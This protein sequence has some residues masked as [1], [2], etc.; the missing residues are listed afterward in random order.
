M[1]SK[2]IIFASHFQCK[3][4]DENPKCLMKNPSF[5]RQNDQ[6]GAKSFREPCYWN[7]NVRWQQL[8]KMSFFCKLKYLTN[9]SILLWIR[10]EKIQNII[11][12]LFLIP[13]VKTSQQTFNRVLLWIVWPVWR[14]WHTFAFKRTRGSSVD[15]WHVCILLWLFCISVRESVNFNIESIHF[16]K[17]SI[18]VVVTHW[19]HVVTLSFNAKVDLANFWV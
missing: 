1:S 14:V 19:K 7:M 6:W 18:I 8:S 10:L 4:T 16:L 17:P 12:A 13:H 15:V 5:V 9:N 2:E 3:M 11:A